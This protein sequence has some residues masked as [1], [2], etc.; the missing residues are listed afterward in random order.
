VEEEEVVDVVNK[1]VFQGISYLKSKRS[2]VIYNMEQDAVGKW[3]ENTSTIDFEEE[4]EEE[5][6]EE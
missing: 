6:E 3:N 4:E 5:Y 2:G 1:I